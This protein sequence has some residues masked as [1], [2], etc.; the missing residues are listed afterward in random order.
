MK[1]KELF[2]ERMS[3]DDAKTPAEFKKEVMEEFDSIYSFDH[4]QDIGWD[5]SVDRSDCKELRNDV[6]SALNRWAERNS[7]NDMWK[8]K[9]SK[10][11]SLWWEG[12]DAWDMSWED[13]VNEYVDPLIK[14]FNSN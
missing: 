6:L 3:W 9:R 12:S 14:W 1:V 5:E 8:Q 2:Q 4:I 11:P 10:M 7:K 13:V